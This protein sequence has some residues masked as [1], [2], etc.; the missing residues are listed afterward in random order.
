[1]WAFAFL[2][3]LD[4]SYASQHT[5]LKVICNGHFRSLLKMYWCLLVYETSSLYKN[6][7]T[8]SLFNHNL[9][10]IE[11]DGEWYEEMPIEDDRGPCMCENFAVSTGSL[12]QIAVPIKRVKQ[13]KGKWKQ[14]PGS[15]INS[16]STVTWF[17]SF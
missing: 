17:A 9:T 15:A 14:E 7:K 10:I 3:K 6:A 5:F 8:K 11:W 4:V 12:T 1:M 13:N 2:Y 16:L